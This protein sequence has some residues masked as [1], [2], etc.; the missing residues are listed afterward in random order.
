MKIYPSAGDDKGESIVKFHSLRST[1][2]GLAALGA[3]LFLSSCGGG[4]AGGNPNQGGPIAVSPVNGTFYA[5]I[6][7]TLTMQ[8]GRK[9]YS[10]TSSEPAIL[11]VPPIVDGNSVQ[12]IGNNP[13]VVDSGLQPGDLPR[14]TVTISVR[15]S[16]GILVNATIAV[17]QNFLTGYGLRLTP[18]NCPTPTVGLAPTACAGGE[19][20]VQMSATFAGSL[21][22]DRLFR[23]E[24]VRGAFLLKDPVTGIVDRTDT[25]NSDHTGTVISLIE[26]PA[27]TGSQLAVIRIIDVATGVYADQVFVISGN[28]ATG[29]L[30]IIPNTI[31]FTGPDSQTCGT[32][33]ADVVVF[34]GVPPF[35]ATS[36]FP[37]DL[38]VTPSSSA[39]PGRFTVQAINP[40]VCLAGAT[41]VFIDSRGG[42]GTLTVTTAFGTK[43]V[44]AMTVSPVAITLG[45][46]QSGA[47]SVVGGSGSFS[48]NTTNA[49]V[50]GGVSGNTL[51]IA[52]AG[53]VGPGAGVLT[54]L[55][56][57]TDGTT[58]VNVTVTSPL[59]CP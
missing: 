20:A 9:P 14:R 47:V 16:T 38:L 37:N 52:R 28:S 46:G 53:P 34:D 23:L 41:I 56:S 25:V 4:G 49:L 35:T 42:H 43:A 21:G 12:L 31:T 54:T 44:P 19:T 6:P 2:A 24:V 11:P 36:T 55:L 58:I 59:T 51:L 39:Q 27:G 15:D 7:G 32:G 18:T 26:V 22:G 3:A 48:V 5:G 33:S 40:F 10:L 50:T 29:G 30:T 8:G 45:C 1:L 57:V 17:A 13:G